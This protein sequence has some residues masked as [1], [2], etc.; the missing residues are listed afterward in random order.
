MLAVSQKT[1]SKMSSKVKNGMYVAAILLLS[2]GART[3]GGNH[4]VA[5]FHPRGAEEVEGRADFENPAGRPRQDALSLASNAVRAGGRR[6]SS[7]S[8]DG[9][10]Q[11]Q[12]ILAGIFRSVEEVELVVGASVS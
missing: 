2:S 1:G 8:R 11:N 5:S 6:R 7:P 10:V 12:W 3:P 9:G 4:K